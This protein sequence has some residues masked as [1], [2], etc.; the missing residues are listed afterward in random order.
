MRIYEVSFCLMSQ[1][2]LFF[3]GDVGRWTTKD[4]PYE[5]IIGHE[6]ARSLAHG[7]SR[8]RKARAAS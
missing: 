7:H 5:S 1:C 6:S 4:P 8:R 2:L 3:L